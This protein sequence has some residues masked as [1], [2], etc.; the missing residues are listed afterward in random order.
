MEWPFWSVTRSWVSL[1]AA[2][3]IFAAVSATRTRFVHAWGLGRVGPRWNDFWSNYFLRNNPVIPSLSAISTRGDGWVYRRFRMVA[4]DRLGVCL[5]CDWFGVLEP[6]EMDLVF[7]VSYRTLVC[8]VRCTESDAL[9]CP[10][11]TY[12]KRQVRPFSARVSRV[13]ALAAGSS[14]S[15]AEPRAFGTISLGMVGLGVLALMTLMTHWSHLHAFDQEASDFDAV[16]EMVPKSPRVLPM[17]LDTSGQISRT[18]PYAH[19]VGYIQ[20]RKGGTFATT[21]PQH[22][23]NIPLSMVENSERSHTPI[24][25]EFLPLGPV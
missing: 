20:V 3:W 12:A 24:A 2:A 14:L 22:F 6:N 19:F 10:S 7:I 13:G 8:C 9:L 23:W 17:N 11:T 15:T 25:F 18:D 21:F 4:A 1:W 16:A 5:G